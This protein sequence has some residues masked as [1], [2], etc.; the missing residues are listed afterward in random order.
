MESS[1]K[2]FTEAKGSQPRIMD[3]IIINNKRRTS[4]PATPH[5]QD[6]ELNG[7]KHRGKGEARV[8]LGSRKKSFLLE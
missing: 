4:L 3:S 5:L 8:C 6:E 7:Q 2:I 1:R